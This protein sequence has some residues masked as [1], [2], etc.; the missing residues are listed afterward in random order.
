MRQTQADFEKE[1]GK[2]LWQENND[3]RTLA[4]QIMWL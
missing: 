2:N 4:L 3:R 1:N